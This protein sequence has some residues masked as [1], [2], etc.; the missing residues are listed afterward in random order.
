MSSMLTVVDL[1]TCNMEHVSD[2]YCYSICKLALEYFLVG[3]ADE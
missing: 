3:M 2:A 1:K